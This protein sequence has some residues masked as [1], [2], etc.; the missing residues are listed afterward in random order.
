MVKPAGAAPHAVLYPTVAEAAHRTGATAVGLVDVGTSAVANLELDQVRIR[1]SNGQSL[2]DPA[3]PVEVSCSLVGGRPVP[4]RA[5]PEVVERIAVASKSVDLLP[6]AVAEVP[7]RVLPVVITT[8]ALSRLR[9][10][11]RLEL[12]QR[13]HDAASGRTVVWVSVEGVGVA[14]TVPTLGDRPASGHSIVGL[15]VL[16]G[17]NRQS[18]AVGRCWSRGQYLAWLAGS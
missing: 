7:S 13:L 11:R 17:S 3:S 5:L 8:W 1:Y 18:E 12:V 6:H 14:P 16:D 9:P 2:G 15:A 4:V 10:R